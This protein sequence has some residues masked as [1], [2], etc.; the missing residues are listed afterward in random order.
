MK[1][2]KG[3]EEMNTLFTQIIIDQI[4]LIRASGAVNMLDSYGVQWQANDRGFCEL[5]I[6]IEENRRAYSNFILTGS[7]G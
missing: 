4:M 5:V 2:Y 6:F 7:I 1:N 3:D